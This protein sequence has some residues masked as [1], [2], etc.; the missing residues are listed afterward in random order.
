MPSAAYSSALR[1][2][3]GSLATSLQ[4]TPAMHSYALA[5]QVIDTFP[6]SCVLLQHAVEEATCN[7]EER[8]AVRRCKFMSVCL[9]NAPLF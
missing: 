1:D 8:H 6:M 2:A 3:S 7:M 5:I 4:P 9:C